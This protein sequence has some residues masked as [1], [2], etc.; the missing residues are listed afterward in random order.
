MDSEGTV[1][2]DGAD[3]DV[4]CEM[5]AGHKST[6]RVQCLYATHHSVRAHVW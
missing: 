6:Q 4:K 5:C 2:S 1:A 3:I